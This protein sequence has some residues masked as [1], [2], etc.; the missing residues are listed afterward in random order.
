MF[1][2]SK[3]TAQPN[4]SPFSVL[5]GHLRKTPALMS[6]T[7]RDTEL[8]DPPSQ[9]G[10]ADTQPAQMEG[11]TK[12]QDELAAAKQPRRKERDP[13]PDNVRLL[14]AIIIC[15]FHFSAEFNVTGDKYSLL[16]YM[17]WGARVP[18]FVLIAGYFSPSKY[19]KRMFESLIRNIAVVFVI[20]TMAHALIN[21]YFGKDFVFQFLSPYLGLWFLVSLVIWRVALPVIIKI[22]YYFVWCCVVALGFG[23]L[24]DLIAVWPITRTFSFLPLFA[25]GHWLRTNSEMQEFLKSRIAKYIAVAFIA[26]AWCFFYLNYRDLKGGRWGMKWAYKGDL[27]DALPQVV[28]RFGIIAFGII[29]AFCVMALVPRGKIPVL[30]ALGAGSFYVYLLHP[31]ILRVLLNLGF[32]KEIDTRY[33]KLAVF[34]GAALLAMALAS[35]PVRKVFRPII[36]PR[37]RIP[38]LSPPRKKVEAGT[39]HVGG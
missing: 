30:T 17:L 28:E 14:A 5:Y 6:T 34:I 39:K 29:F 8:L 10:G 23:V 35:P 20:F 12:A 19:S 37:Y 32:F 16:W 3:A 36:Q 31:L 24:Q 15:C 26:M 7:S 27:A 33:E 1:T 2:K 25:L 22:P 18:V 38:F 21:V 11:D 4:Q 13:W 9:G